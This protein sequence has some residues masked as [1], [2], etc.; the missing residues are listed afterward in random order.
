M[1]AARQLADETEAR[2]ARITGLAPFSSPEFRAPQM[3]SLRLPRTDPKKLQ[4]D[5]MAGWS[6]EIPCFDWQDNTIARIST[7]G[8]TTRAEADLLVSALK[9]LLTLSDAA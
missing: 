2:M 8:Y 4:Q 7:A 9:S 6:I 3:A 5:L 1:A